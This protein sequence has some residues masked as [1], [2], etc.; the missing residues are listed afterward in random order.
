MSTIDPQAT[1]TTNAPIDDAELDAQGWAPKRTR[2]GRAFEWL[3]DN[4][5]IV[6]VLVLL[7]SVGG[8]IVAPFDFN[9]PIPRTPV[10]VDAIPDIGENQQ[11]VQIDWPGRSPKDIEDQIAYPLS[12]SL[13]SVTGVTTVRTQAMLG[14]AS[15][16]VIFDEATE[17]YWSRTRIQEV[18]SGLS[19]ATLPDDATVKL[20]PPASPLGQIYWY[21]LEGRDEAGNPA[22]GWDLHELRRIQDYQVRYALREVAGVAEVASIG[23]H[24]RALVVEPDL[25]ELDARGIGIQELYAALRDVSVEVGAS[26]TELQGVEYVIRSEGFVRDLDAVRKALVRFENDRPVMVEDIARVSFQPQERQGFLDR[27]GAE[28]VGGIVVAQHGA[29]P[30]AVA[31]GVHEAVEA[32]Q[33]SL[34][35]KALPDGRTSQ[36]H[37]VPYL[38][39][40]ELI[41][42]TVGTLWESLS[43][44]VMITIVVVLLLLAHVRTAGLVALLLPLAVLWTFLAMHLF[45]V[46]ANVVSLAGIAIAIGTMVDLG[47][48]MSENIVD[49]LSIK[50]RDVPLKVAIAEASAE[51][52]GAMM[53]ALATTGLSFLPVFF[54]E[55][56]EGK[57]FHPLAFTKTA[58]LFFAFL[59]SVMVIPVIA[60]LLFHPRATA[61]RTQWLT[62]VLSLGAGIY[63]QSTGFA[64]AG[65]ALIA[66]AALLA[67]SLI[68]AIRTRLSALPLDAMARWALSVAAIA[69]LAELWAPTGGS[70]SPWM[71]LLLV[72]GIILLTTGFFRAFTI[73][74]PTL[75]RSFLRH[76]HAFMLL[77]TA[78]VFV[79]FIAWQGAGK[80]S[81]W[82]SEDFGA[83]VG[84]SAIGAA[85][86]G[87]GG[88]FMPELNEGAFLYMPTTAPHA[89]IGEVQ[90]LSALLTQRFEAIPEVKS[91][92]TK[93]GRAD[94]ALDPAPISMLETVITYHPE[95]IQH[96]DGTR[97]RFAVDRKGEFL[98]DEHGELIPDRTGRAYRLWRDEIETPQDIWNEVVH[99]GDIPGL[100][101]APILQPISAR[102]VMLQSGIRAATALRIRGPSL[103]QIYAHAEQLEAYLREHPMIAR[104][105]VVADRA[106]GRP[107][108]VIQ[109]DRVALAEAGLTMGQFQEAVSVGIG[110]GQVGVYYD[111]RA[112]Y[113]ITLRA[114]RDG[115]IDIEAIERLPVRGASGA[116]LPLREVARVETEMGPVMTTT[117]NNALVTWVMF[118]PRGEISELTL[119]DQ[120]KL[121]LDAAI[122]SGELQLDDGVRLDFVGSYENSVRATKRLSLL[123]PV[124][125]LIIFILLKMQ[126]R[127]TI[128]TAFVFA[129]V[130]VAAAGG[131]IWLWLY[132]Q[133]GFLDITIFG[134]N[135][136]DVMQVQTTHLSVAVWVGF[137]ALSGIA[138]DD[139]V[140]M[141]TWLQQRFGEHT[142]NNVPAIREQVLEVALR[143]LRPCLMTTATTLLALLPVITS[144]G[145]GSDI[146][147][148]MAI[149]TF[150][151]MLFAL[152]TLFVVPVLYASWQER[153]LAR[154]HS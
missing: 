32:L 67:L 61:S 97:A 23:G 84:E 132:G 139:G 96:D 51:V 95:Y 17:Y 6:F 114:P 103:E 75:L 138:T 7:L 5:L 13:T 33:A 72:A 100:T 65:L 154:S 151:G 11:I 48:V 66:S 141:A 146:M 3:I 63:L 4:R 125:L 28:A 119:V 102:V 99:A 120:L 24:T 109:P 55:G 77:P 2:S 18:L 70:F 8:L 83:W 58:A 45:Q 91:A 79:G 126:L 57:L 129:S 49:R 1:D 136:R 52:S 108:L 101:G 34:P 74:Y 110:G 117:E 90:R 20:G 26:S 41:E 148:P 135:A 80:V 54:L 118:S 35:A 9:L 87:I 85:F 69:A 133:P 112:R 140:L 62:L 105:A 16:Y 111:G 25:L 147:M 71:N 42:A 134:A 81:G 149:P 94:T 150:G 123:I 106:A 107:Y 86:P 115:R 121:D 36:L 89:S 14:S 82:I 88:E 59:V 15:I 46:T 19:S 12:T 76:K 30:M 152:I 40:S 73:I 43:Q 124:V 56:A 92:V 116:T 128:V 31:E 10:A 143:R 47:I 113:P 153:R 98:R 130:A 27:G 39:R 44:A 29:N 93:A 21:T 144:R 122:A 104:E 145:T 53:T 22:G 78:L 38:D 64:W 137:I 131:M 127:D 37:V 142:P 50:R 68:P 60:H